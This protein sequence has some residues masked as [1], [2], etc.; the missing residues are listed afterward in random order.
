MKEIDKV[1]CPRLVHIAGHV[2]G[3]AFT[4]TDVARLVRV[5]EKE[6]RNQSKRRRAPVLSR[7]VRF[8]LTPT[9]ARKEVSPTTLVGFLPTRFRVG[10][11]GRELGLEPLPHAVGNPR[12][13]RASGVILR[14]WVVARGLSRRQS[15]S[16]VQS[17][18]ARRID[19]RKEA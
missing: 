7:I 11:P 8:V 19:A 12:Q 16:S 17:A 3:T 10:K 18:T 14:E 2:F 4:G 1:L 9:K 5:R 6:R 13:Q 15:E